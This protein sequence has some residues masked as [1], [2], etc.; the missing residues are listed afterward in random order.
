MNIKILGNK[1]NLREIDKKLGD[2]FWK[3]LEVAKINDMVLL[4]ESERVDTTG[5]VLLGRR[6]LLFLK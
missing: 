1:Y 5:D 3:P 2:N 4:L 6:C